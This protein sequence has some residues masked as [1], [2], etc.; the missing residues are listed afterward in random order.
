MRARR[1]SR[2]EEATLLL[3]AS[4]LWSS[5]RQ[6][7]RTEEQRRSTGAAA[8][9]NPRALRASLSW[10]PLTAGGGGNW[11]E[12]LPI[13]RSAEAWGVRDNEALPG[14]RDGAEAAREKEE[15]EDKAGAG[16]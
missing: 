13:R 1:G 7:E 10:G 4:A 5:D 16:S 2:A 11:W 12:T 6:V 3:S 15:E 9:A 8:S 14:W